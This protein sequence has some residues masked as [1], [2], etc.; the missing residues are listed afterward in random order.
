MTLS[1]DWDTRRQEIAYL[2]DKPWWKDSSSVK[3]RYFYVFDDDE[4]DEPPE[5][6]AVDKHTPHFMNLCGVS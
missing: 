4:Y 5:V 6:L 2:D 3:N 1:L